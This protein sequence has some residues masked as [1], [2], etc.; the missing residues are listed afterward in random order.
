VTLYPARRAIGPKTF[1]NST[2]WAGVRRME[3]YV[4]VQSGSLVNPRSVTPM[5]SWP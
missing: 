5:P 3:S 1:V 4:A 2:A